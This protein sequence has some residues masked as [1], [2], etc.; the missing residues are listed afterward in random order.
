MGDLHQAVVTLQG[1]DGSKLELG[2]PES[3]TGNNWRVGKLA[4]PNTYRFS[5]SLTNFEQVNLQAPM[6]FDRSS[7]MEQESVVGGFMDFTIGMK[8]KPKLFVEVVD[9]QDTKVVLTAASTELVKLDSHGKPLRGLTREESVTELG[10]G[11]VREALVDIPGTYAIEG[12]L[13]SYK[14]RNYLTPFH[15]NQS[16]WPHDRPLK[17]TLRMELDSV[18]WIRAVDAET[19]EDIQGAQCEIMDKPSGN[20]LNVTTTVAGQESALEEEEQAAYHRFSI[21]DQRNKGLPRK[22]QTSSKRRVRADERSGALSSC[23]C[24]G[25]LQIRVSK[26]QYETCLE[27]LE[28]NRQLWP[29]NGPLEVVCRMLRARQPSGIS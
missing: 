4:M 21:Q 25:E 26:D 28:V 2:R 16:C 7:W 17:I 9:A 23:P 8:L 11:G 5:A 1:S 24:P 20:T 19:G 29:Q 18:L 22:T 14:Q 12:H 15:L 13:P 10:S 27:N 3:K 6:H